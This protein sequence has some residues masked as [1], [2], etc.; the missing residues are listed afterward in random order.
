MGVFLDAELYMVNFLDPSDGPR[1]PSKMSPH[2]H[3]FEQCSL[4]IEGEFVHH[5]RWPWTTDMSQWR[6]DD[7]EL[8]ASPSV[9]VIPAGARTAM[10]TTQATGSGVNQ[11]VDIFCPR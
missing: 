1:D 6:P 4:A 7:H 3:D 9:A 10:H 11:L 5:L 8:C 2:S